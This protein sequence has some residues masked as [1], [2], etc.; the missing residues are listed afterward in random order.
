LRRAKG[1]EDARIWHD[2][3]EIGRLGPGGIGDER[4]V[5]VNVARLNFLRGCGPDLNN[6]PLLLSNCQDRAESCEGG[7]ERAEE[8]MGRAAGVEERRHITLV[9]DEGDG[10]VNE[11][12]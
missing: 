4:H 10:F 3:G 1:D 8:L 12:L 7:E 5:L 11:D 9:D 6:D 2:V